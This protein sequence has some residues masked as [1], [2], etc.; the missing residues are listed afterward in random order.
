MFRCY[1]GEPCQRCPNLEANALWPRGWSDMCFEPNCNVP[2]NRRFMFPS[3]ESDYYFRCV[4]N[5]NHWTF[6]RQECRC[7]TLFNMKSQEW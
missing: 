3:R 6:Q 7:G 2:E 4:Y 1:E 5:T